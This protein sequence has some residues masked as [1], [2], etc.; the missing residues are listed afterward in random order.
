[1]VIRV[2][3]RVDRVV[4]SLGPL[5]SSGLYS[6]AFDRIVAVSKPEVA[7]MVKLYENCHRIM[8]I[9]YANEIVD[10]YTPYGIDP[11]E[12]AAQVVEKLTNRRPRRSFL[13]H[14]TSRFEAGQ[15][16]LSNSPGLGLIK[17]LCFSK[18]VDVVFADLL[19]VE[20]N[21]SILDDI[22]LNSFIVITRHRTVLGILAFEPNGG[23]KLGAIKGNER[24]ED[25]FIHIAGYID[26]TWRD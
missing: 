26:H 21:C 18:I 8:C 5:S 19:E 22:K 12:I 9:A 24:F 23:A 25:E 13:A 14:I 2:Q 16:T 20:L 1:M 6:A 7:E 15:P 17:H 3:R 4:S 11:Y 10:A